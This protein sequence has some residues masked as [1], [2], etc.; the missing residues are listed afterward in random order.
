MFTATISWLYFGCSVGLLTDNLYSGEHFQTVSAHP[1]C[2]PLGIL[3]SDGSG[4]TIAARRFNR[5]SRIRR[6]F[7]RSGECEAAADR[8][9][10]EEI[11]GFVRGLD[12][13]AE[14]NSF[15]PPHC[16][17]MCWAWWDFESTV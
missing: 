13:S 8:R 12:A 2:R 14:Q 15:P 17:S 6:S 9:E 3:L 5:K 4:K 7:L 11:Y 1:S 16:L 10:E